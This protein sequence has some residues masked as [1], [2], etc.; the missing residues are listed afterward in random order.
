MNLLIS[1]L[2]VYIL[3]ISSSCCVISRHRSTPA[4]PPRP[5]TL[6]THWVGM[7]LWSAVQYYPMYPPP[8][9]KQEWQKSPAGTRQTDGSLVWRNRKNISQVIKDYF[10]LPFFLLIILCSY[11]SSY[12]FSNSSSSAPAATPAPIPH[13]LLLY[14]SSSSCFILHSPCFSS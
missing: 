8:W 11:Y 13:L 1:S 12:S 9:L 4:P 10:C 14:S 5:H 7:T 2:T 3:S 6:C